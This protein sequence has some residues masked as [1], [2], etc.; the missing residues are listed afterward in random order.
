M[1]APAGLLHPWQRPEPPAWPQ[2][3]HRGAGPPGGGRGPRVR[4]QLPWSRQRPG[5]W[6]SGCKGG[7]NPYQGRQLQ[8]LKRRNFPLLLRGRGAPRGPR[9]QSEKSRERMCPMR[10]V[11]EAHQQRQ[12]APGTQR[13]PKEHD[14]LLRGRRRRPTGVGRG[15]LSGVESVDERVDLRGYP[16]VADKDERT[17]DRNHLRARSAG[18]RRHHTALRAISLRWLSGRERLGTTQ[19]EGDEG[20]LET[21]G[22][23]KCVWQGRLCAHRIARA[24]CGSSFALDEALLAV[25]GRDT[26]K[27]R[28]GLKGAV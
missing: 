26:R 4:A 10:R 16:R 3:G 9:T 21:S 25:K 13:V 1:T 19:G 28:E 18:T 11:S 24:S 22:Q 7:R 5:E 20:P 8:G 17:R 23:Q 27:H 12:R 2:R 15:A 14:E 6:E